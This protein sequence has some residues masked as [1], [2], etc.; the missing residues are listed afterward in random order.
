MSAWR[1]AGILHALEDWHEHECGN[2]MFDIEKVW[3]ASLD[4]G[5]QQITMAS[6]SESKA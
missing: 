5:F 3:K 1:I 2:M 4:H 6:A